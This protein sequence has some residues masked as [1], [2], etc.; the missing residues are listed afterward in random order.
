[1]LKKILTTLVITILLLGGAAAQKS[2][3]NA[4]DNI[5]GTYEGVKEGDK[6]HAKIVKLPN[7]TYR[8]QITWVEHDRDAQ[9]KKILDANNPDKSLRSTPCDQI[10]LFSGLQYDSKNHEWNGTK[11]Y[12]P[13]RGIRAKLVAHF[14]NDAT[15]HLRGSIMG[16][17]ETV[18]WT[19]LP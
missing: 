1:M 3:N 13:Q 6:F 4:A 15:L 18:V 14:A 8:G 19:R 5:V 11:I 16:I 12:D 17:G 7:G 10:I 9:G 2:L